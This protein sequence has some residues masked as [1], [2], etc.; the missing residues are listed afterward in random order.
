MSDL[1]I[2]IIEYIEKNNNISKDYCYKIDEFEYIQDTIY[3]LNMNIDLMISLYNIP[4][5]AIEG[6]KALLEVK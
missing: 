3:D 1:M 2:E 4:T 6:L 5:S